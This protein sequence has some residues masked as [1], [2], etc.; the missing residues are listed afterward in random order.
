MAPGDGH[1]IKTTVGLLG[2]G[3]MQWKVI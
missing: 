2:S 1:P 3:H